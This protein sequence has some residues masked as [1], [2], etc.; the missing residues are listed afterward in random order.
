MLTNVSWGQ[1]LSLSAGAFAIYYLGIGLTCYR[2]ELAGVLKGQKKSADPRAPKAP[3]TVNFSPLALS[4]DEEE[5]DEEGYGLSLTNSGPDDEQALYD[6]ADSLTT[7]LADLFYVCR[8]EEWE[9]TELES[10]LRKKLSQYPALAKS[11]LAPS[12]VGYIVDK[13]KEECSM[14]FTE[15]EIK[16]LW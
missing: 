10:L 9:K 8:C 13:A 3:A 2:L 6:D 11:S 7:D 15:S 4:E 12:F 16:A 1:F 5:D 14:E